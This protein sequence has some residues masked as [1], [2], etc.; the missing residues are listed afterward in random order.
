M[1]GR[2]VFK[3]AVTKFPEVIN[4]A[5]QCNGMGIEDIDL[6]IPHQANKRITETVRKTMGISEDRVIS[7]IHRYGNTTSA[8]I[9]IALSEAKDGGRV[10]D[11]D[12]VVLAAFGSGFLY[13][14]VLIRW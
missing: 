4:E 14:S 8:S 11:G 12:I 6:L 13:G 5:L 3:H 7:N 1:N 2:E 9:P 10:K